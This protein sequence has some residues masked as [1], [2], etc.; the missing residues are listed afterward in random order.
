M[1]VRRGGL[2]QDGGEDSQDTRL[3]REPE[4][5]GAVRTGQLRTISRRMFSAKII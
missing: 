4:E 2:K 1:F 3:T 5:G